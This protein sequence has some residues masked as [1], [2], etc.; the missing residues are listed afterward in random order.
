M[1]IELPESDQKALNRLSIVAIP[2][3]AKRPFLPI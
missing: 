1:E 3:V 2:T